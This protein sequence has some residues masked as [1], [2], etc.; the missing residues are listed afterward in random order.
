MKTAKRWITIPLVLALLLSCLVFPVS[1]ASHPFTDVPGGAWYA[2]Y[3]QYVYENGL[4][5]GTSPTTF[6][7]ATKMDRAMLITVLYRMDGSRSVSGS[8]PFTD[9]RTDGYY[10]NALVWAY[11][12]QI[13]NGTSPT[14]FSPEL[15]ISREMMV[16]IFYRCSQYMGRAVSKLDGLASYRDAGSISDYAKTAFQWAVANGIITGTEPNKLSPQGN[17]PRE[18]CAAMLKRFC[19]W[20]DANAAVHTHQYLGSNYVAPTCTQEGYIYGKCSCGA[21][22]KTTTYASYGHSYAPAGEQNGKLVYRCN[23]CQD[24]YQ[25]DITARY[26][27]SLTPPQV[28]RAHAEHYYIGVNC[29]ADFA[30]NSGYGYQCLVAKDKA[31]TT[32]LQEDSEESQWNNL[33]YVKLSFFDYSISSGSYFYKVRAYKKENGV[34]VYGPWSEIGQVTCMS[35]STQLNRK[36]QY[37]YEIYFMDN[38]GSN[39]YTKATKAIYIK[40]QNPE[41]SSIDLTVNEESILGNI[42]QWGG[43]QYYDDVNYL[44]LSDY[45]EPLHKVDGGYLGMLSIETAGLLTV[46]LREA[47]S[48]GYVVAKTFRLN[49]LDYETERNKWIDNVIAT[50]TNSSMNPK[51]KMDAIAAYL[52]Q[53][54]F[55]YL[56][57]TNG[58]LVSLASIP[59]GPWFQSMRWDSATSP[60]MLAVF[61]ERIGGFEEIH[62][63]FGDYVRGTA[64]WY[65][66]HAKTYVVYEGQKYYYVVCPLT[67]TGEVGTVNPIDFSNTAQLTLIA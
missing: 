14:R 43:G 48:E 17:A 67:G 60:A 52:E 35:F 63:C 33:G 31:F 44:S 59:N 27:G 41:L 30:S 49:V 45:D 7:P 1:A 40:T 50:Q 55:R 36:A 19:L 6:S 57:N 9:V 15:S 11:Q 28:E 39:V 5:N 66:Y 37:S 32:G 42:Q 29:Y 47:S 26:D 4:M 18:Q 10:Y 54:Q 46:E 53:G 3:V 56:T 24:S 12:N 23:R 65:E 20:L 2:E 25:Q 58:T 62:N 51:Q 34:F 8:T 16:T 21:I 13:I 64:E 61:A 38:L 22:Q